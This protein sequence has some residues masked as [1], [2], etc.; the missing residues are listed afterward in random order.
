MKIMKTNREEFLEKH[1][2]PMKTS[3]S[4]EEISQLSKMPIGALQEVYNRGTG[5]YRSNPS[6]VRVEGSFKK[7]VPGRKL[8]VQQ[9][10]FGRVY[11]FVMK[12]QK[13]FYSADRD[14]SFRFGLL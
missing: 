3:L 14:I 11:A 5:A 9:W 1:N 7:G 8:S 6:S 12:T 4:L 10:S 2:L 13:V